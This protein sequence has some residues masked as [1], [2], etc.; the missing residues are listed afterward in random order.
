MTP[1]ERKQV[2]TAVRAY[3]LN[4]AIRRLVEGARKTWVL[5]VIFVFTVVGPALGDDSE[6][7]VALRLLTFVAG[8]FAGGFAVFMSMEKR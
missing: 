2:R 6:G 1:H 8:A 4:T 5:W 7:M 3:W